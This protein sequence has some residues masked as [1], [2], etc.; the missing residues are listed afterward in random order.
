MSEKERKVE[1]SSLFKDVA[2]VLVEKCVNPATS[3]PYTM[4]LIERALRDV[5]FAVDPKRSAKQQA[6]EALPLLKAR[7]PIERAMMR[8]ELQVAL[9]VQPDLLALLEGGG[10]RVEQQE[11][12]ADV[13]SATCL[14]QP[15][16]TGG[17]GWV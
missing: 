9:A 15:G 11:L 6:L 16:V 1:L 14:I 5:H 2:S 12:L 4:G 17:K 7:F 8:V 3:R 13:F 10:A